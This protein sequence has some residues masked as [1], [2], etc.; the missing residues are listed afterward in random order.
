MCQVGVD[1]YKADRGTDEQTDMPKLIVSF[2]SFVKG[3]KKK[4]LNCCADVEQ[5]KVSIVIH[6]YVL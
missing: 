3:T 1:L 2:L 5:N 6:F 4:Y